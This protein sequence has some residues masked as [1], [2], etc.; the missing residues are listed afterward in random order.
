MVIP[1]EILSDYKELY[2]KSNDLVENESRSD[3]PTEPF[4]SHYKARDILQD[5]KKQLEDQLVSVAASE[6]D[7]GQDELSY[8]SILAFVC[9]DLGRIY[10]YTEEPTEGVRM[11]KQCLELIESHKDTGD[12]IIPYVGA[13]NELSIVLGS[14]QEYKQAMEMLLE[15]EKSY[16]Q[17]KS[18]GQVAHSLMDIFSPPD[19][20]SA[21]HSG[22][23][24]LENLY[25]LCCFY[26][27][28]MFGHLG[29][30]EK[31]AQFC[32]RT[33]HRQLEYKS[34]DAI[35]FA[36]NTA[37]LSQYYIGE[38]RFKEARHHLAAATLI[39]AEYE[40]V[41]LKPEMTEQQKADVSET[42]KHR[43]ADV[44]R[45]WAKYGLY[46]LQTS[47][48]RLLRDDQEEAQRS[49]EKAM[50]QLE[51]SG[52][53]EDYRFLDLNL[54]ACENR[55]SCDYCLTFDD[56]KLVFHFVNEWLDIAKD[57]YKAET[58][59]TEY[60][61]IIQDYAEAYEHIVFFEEN[62]DNQAKMHK[63]RAKFLEDLL[64]LI[65]PVFYLKICR[66]CWYGAGTANA[67][68][69]DIRLD[70]IKAKNSP[71]PDEI[72]KANQSCMKAIK[73]FQ[74]YAKSYLSAN[75]TDWRP[76]MDV[77]EQRI[78]LYAHFHIGRLY[79][80]LLTANPMQ[81]LEHLNSCNHYYKL[82]NDGCESH[83]EAAGPLHGETGVVREMLHLLPLKIEAVKARLH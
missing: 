55:I 68:V 30:L 46:L 48:E 12:G 75:G 44:A 60:C 77:E 8:K 50:K 52:S 26:L 29:E 71:S 56:A 62:P 11:L 1:K 82:F 20:T 31:S 74:S 38:E 64:D 7:G 54:T 78:M 83:P 33:L 16:Q 65:D 51:I 25:T 35:D 67:A 61:K 4:R 43:Y 66:E 23:T 80:K 45:C 72:K 15:A 59:A 10:V 40:G 34:Y 32:H 70:A 27:A 37:T 6:E 18:S 14:R 3:P 21:T 73:H 47:K 24:E 5:L 17:F 19:D 57:Y 81:Q 22:P 41:M 13:I 42:F 69:L 28:Q 9:R 53:Q 76:N 36:L 58:E 2:E 49:A 39:M 79:Y 63:K